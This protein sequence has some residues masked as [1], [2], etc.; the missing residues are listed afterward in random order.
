MRGEPIDPERVKRLRQRLGLSQ[1]QL[2]ERLGVTLG[3]IS[4][5]ELGKSGPIKPYL[6]KLEAL[7]RQVE[8]QQG[9]KGVA[10]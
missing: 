3:S 6:E 7:E 2:A 5:W 8:R 9:G 1:Q 10:A 4:R